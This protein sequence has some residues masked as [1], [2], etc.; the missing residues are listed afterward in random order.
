MTFEIPL[1]EQKIK[2]H[3]VTA[4]H[5]MIGF[6]LLAAGAFIIFV[7]SEMALIPFTWAQLPKE[8]AGNMHSILWPEYIMMG[9][10][11]MILFISLLKNNWLLKPGNNKI[12][13]AVELALCAVI[14]GYSLYTN[15]M[16]LAGMFGILSIAIIYSF[17]AE[18]TRGQQ[19]AVVI[20]ENGINLPMNVRRRHINW[21][22]TEKV[23]L[24]HGTLTINCLDN[25]LYQWI[26]TQ[27][28]VDTTT[29]EAF[30]IAHIEAAQKDRKKY[31]W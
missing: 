30:C 22:E 27:N 26:T 6:A 15:A 23:L 11:L 13:R 2:P 9:A 12:I 18:N 14:A 16:V 7:F 8:S 17:Y 4:L 10:G 29:F 1:A 28:N 20:N 5:L 3:Q 25:R 21:A 19:P 24:R 31:D